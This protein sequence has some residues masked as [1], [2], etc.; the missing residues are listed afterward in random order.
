MNGTTH[1]FSRCIF[2]RIILP[3]FIIGIGTIYAQSPGGIHVDQ[4]YAVS[5]QLSS[6]YSHGKNGVSLQVSNASV[7]AGWLDRSNPM[8]SNIMLVGSTDEN[9][10]FTV[11]LPAYS[12]GELLITASKDNQEWMAIVE[13]SGQTFQNQFIVPITF[14]TTLA[15]D[16]YLS[17]L[18]V[19]NPSDVSYAR[20]LNSIQSE[21][22]VM[23]HGM[24]NTYSSVNETFG[25]ADNSKLKQ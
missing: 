7:T 18:R 13:I 14:E 12:S 21:T 3:V 22:S 9:G 15:T 5:G 6:G 1:G 2:I 17:A 8:A 16:L 19:M 20:I 23:D 10:H 4:F 25:I 11:V 24:D